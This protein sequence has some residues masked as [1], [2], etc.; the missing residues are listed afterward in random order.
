MRSGCGAVVL[1][2][3]VRVCL[4]LM[5]PLL[6]ISI[7]P[8]FASS[9]SSSASPSLVSQDHF[10]DDPRGMRFPRPATVTGKEAKMQQY[11]RTC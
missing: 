6:H 1:G 4:L 5:L 8:V 9:S 10:A 2:C 7:A 3:D 11:N